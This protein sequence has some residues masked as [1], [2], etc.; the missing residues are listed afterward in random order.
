[1]K[2]L[3]LIAPVLFAC[4][5][6]PAPERRPI[7]NGDAHLVE[8]PALV[9]DSAECYALTYTNA[10][11]GASERLFPGW[12]ALMP[13]KYGAPAVGKHNPA[14]SDAEWAAISEFHG[15]RQISADSIEVRF[16]GSTEGLSIRI[17]RNGENILGHA[18]WLTDLIGRPEASMRVTATRQSCPGEILS[19]KAG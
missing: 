17:P 6:R 8:W 3:P 16:T 5:T 12:I 2:Y 19:G 10:R 1:M 9:L 13:G 4:A 11:N 18:I 14:F 15:W 7:V